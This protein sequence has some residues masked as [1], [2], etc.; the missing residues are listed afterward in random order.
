MT[1]FII[2]CVLMCV[3]A[4]A[5][6][7]LPLW[8]GSRAKAE[9]DRRSQVLAILQQQANDLEAERAAGR[10]DQ[11]EYEETRSELERRVWKKPSTK[12]KSRAGAA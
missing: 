3:A 9:S 1:I 11:D 7:C 10:I 6:V 4:V 12:K 5:A 2:L 8:F